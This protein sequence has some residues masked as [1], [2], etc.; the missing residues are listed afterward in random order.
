MKVQT[1]HDVSWSCSDTDK[2][3]CTVHYLNR[4]MLTAPRSNVKSIKGWNVRR[5]R[6][7]DVGKQQRADERGRQKQKPGEWMRECMLVELCFLA[8]RSGVRAR[9]CT[10]ARWFISRSLRRMLSLLP[11]SSSYRSYFPPVRWKRTINVP[12]SR[13]KS[14]LPARDKIDLYPFDQREARSAYAG[15]NLRFRKST[16]T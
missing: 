5:R 16:K 8:L 10:S 12:V 14:W 3:L 7:K 4:Y 15:T 6:P 13:Y 2:S 11:S 1:R 9:V